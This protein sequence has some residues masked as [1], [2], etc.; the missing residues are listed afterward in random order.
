MINSV[1]SK[2]FGF[3]QILK[4]TERERKLKK[5]ILAIDT[6]AGTKLFTNLKI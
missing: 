3:E 5:Y 1:P 2:M 4:K 6:L